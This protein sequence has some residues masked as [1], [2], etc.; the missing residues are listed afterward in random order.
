MMDFATAWQR[1]YKQGCKAWLK[2]RILSTFVMVIKTYNVQL[3]KNLMYLGLHPPKH[4][5]LHPC[6]NFHF[7]NNCHLLIG[8]RLSKNIIPKFKSCTY[9]YSFTYGAHH[10]IIII[11]LYTQINNI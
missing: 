11:S 2:K 1:S 7:V 8:Q 4:K 9:A 6:E 3:P 5:K 10:H